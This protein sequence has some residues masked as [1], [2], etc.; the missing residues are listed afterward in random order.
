MSLLFRCISVTQIQTIGSQKHIYTIKV[1]SSALLCLLKICM[2]HLRRMQQKR[3]NYDPVY[4]EVVQDKVTQHCCSSFLS[5]YRRAMHFSPGRSMWIF[6]WF[7]APCSYHSFYD[8]GFLLCFVFAHVSV[9]QCACWKVCWDSGQS[10]KQSASGLTFH[11]NTIF[12]SHSAFPLSSLILHCLG[13]HWGKCQCTHLLWVW[14]SNRGL[15]TP[16]PEMKSGT[17]LRT[18]R[19]DGKGEL[20]RLGLRHQQLAG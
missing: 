19:G 9:S 15:A 7:R 1:C 2:F 20:I 18:T 16:K 6:S 12:T 14:P 10:A 11:S 13:L 4:T 17:G 3:T 8:A 5:L